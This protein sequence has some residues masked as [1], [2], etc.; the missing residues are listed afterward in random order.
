VKTLLQRMRE[1]AGAAS[2]R[3]QS[4]P[5]PAGAAIE[6]LRR[7]WPIVN[8]AQVV[9]PLV[10]AILCRWAVDARLI[11][12]SAMWRIY[13]PLIGVALVFAIAGEILVRLNL[14]E[15][16]KPA[17]PL[18]AQDDIPILRPP[19]PLRQDAPQTDAR[20]AP[21]SGGGE[22]PASRLNSLGPATWRLEGDYRWRRQQD[23]A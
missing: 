5:A 7:V 19:P 6:R 11:S 13:L 4:A 2:P 20:A 17:A 16:R 3:Q 22:I 8:A 1:L 15:K 23:E 12:H 10:G 14:V 21:H 9:L 18:I